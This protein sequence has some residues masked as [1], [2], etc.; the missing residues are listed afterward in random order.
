[1][2]VVSVQLPAVVVACLLAVPVGPAAA[3]DDPCANVKSGAPQ[4]QPGAPRPPLVIGDSSELLAVEPLVR[5]GLEANARGCRPLSAAVDMLAER[6]AAGTLPRVAVLGVGANGG[7]QRSLLRQALRIMGPRGMLG[8]VTPA[9]TPAAAK[10]MRSFHARHPTRTVLIDWAA[11]GQAQRYPGDGIHIGDEGEA[12][13]ARYIARRVRPYSLPRTTIVFPARPAEAKACGE[14]HRGGRTLQVLVIR[15]R[16]RV[17]CSLARQLARAAD[18]T[19]ARYF[20]W[21]DWRFLG[22]GPWKDVFVRA[23]GR[24]VIAT[25]TPAPAPAPGTH[26][27]AR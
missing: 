13:L 20:R 8:V 12:V 27:P 9:T 17:L 24:V 14:V 23:D 16:D 7:V 3:Q 15:G 25:R 5:L 6:R 22:R 10:A 1:V 2:R 19:A 18:K 21:F 26:P 11:T 4:R